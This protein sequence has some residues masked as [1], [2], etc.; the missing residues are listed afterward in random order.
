MLGE[1]M[2]Q[3]DEGA[4]EALGEIFF[5]MA[6]THNRENGNGRA[7][8]NLLEC[9][10]RSQALRLMEMG[11][12][13]TKEELTLLTEAEFEEPLAEL[14]AAPPPRGGGTPRD[15]GRA[16]PPAHAVAAA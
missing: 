4:R 15:D 2:L 13:R 9:A 12:R 11:G 3:L 8:R 6:A 16:P 7:V 10:K 14:R 5:A 1:E